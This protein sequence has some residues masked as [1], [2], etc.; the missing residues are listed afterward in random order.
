MRLGGAC[1]QRPISINF[2]V[3]LVKKNTKNKYVESRTRN[4][5]E[6]SFRKVDLGDK[7]TSKFTHVHSWTPHHGFSRSRQ[8]VDDEPSRACAVAFNSPRPLP[9]GRRRPIRRQCLR[10]L[11]CLQTCQDSVSVI[12]LGKD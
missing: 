1:L 7:N 4:W 5:D 11:S 3:F 9:V 12:R 10:S 6:I 8:H 2:L